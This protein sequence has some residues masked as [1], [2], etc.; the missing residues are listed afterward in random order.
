LQ[1]CS[2]QSL[3]SAEARLE[4]ALDLVCLDHLDAAVEDVLGGK[5]DKSNRSGID[6][7]I[8]GSCVG[9][10]PDKSSPTALVYPST[11][12]RLPK[13]KENQRYPFNCGEIQTANMIGLAF[14]RS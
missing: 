4:H 12:T 1:S 2:Q 11:L 13:V 6:N 8:K 3:P 7:F 14:R 5:P 10:K 9:G